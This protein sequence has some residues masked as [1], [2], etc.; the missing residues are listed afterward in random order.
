MCKGDGRR[1]KLSY[2][3]H[4]RVSNLMSGNLFDENFPIILMTTCGHLIHDDCFQQNQRVN[5]F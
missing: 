3:C 4:Y 1:K 2:L 5:D